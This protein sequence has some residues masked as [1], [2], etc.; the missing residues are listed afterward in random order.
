MKAIEIIQAMVYDSSL[1]E[2]GGYVEWRRDI[3]LRDYF[4]AVSH[5]GEME[6]GF[7]FYVYEDQYD[8]LA[9]LP[10]ADVVA[11][12]ED[13]GDVYLWKVEG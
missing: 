9:Q 10:A 5:R 6:C 3:T 12:T 7:W 13:A 2:N 8:W 4:G 1:A 11:T